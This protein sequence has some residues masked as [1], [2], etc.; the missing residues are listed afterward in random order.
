[1]LDK[2]RFETALVSVGDVSSRTALHVFETLTSKRGLSSVSLSSIR[3]SLFF[4]AMNYEVSASAKPEDDRFLFGS[5]S[6]NGES[7]NRNGDTSFDHRSIS[8]EY[9]LYNDA[10]SSSTEDNKFAYVRTVS[11]IR[12]MLSV[13]YIE[14][15][16]KSF[17]LKDLHLLGLQAAN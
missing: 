4:H 7:N 2:D 14:R 9:Q 17:G 5:Q 6:S 1:M 15:H 10:G 12:E 11:R 3:A 8:L 16:Q 13:P